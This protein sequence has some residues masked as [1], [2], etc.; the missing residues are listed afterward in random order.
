MNR[1]VNIERRK[2]FS[3]FEGFQ[4]K[5]VFFR[6]NQII[7]N[8]TCEKGAE[9]DQNCFF[10]RVML[11]YLLLLTGFHKLLWTQSKKNVSASDQKRLG[12]FCSCPSLL[13]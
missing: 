4:T 1:N 5:L 7:K 9:R 6:K 12:C 3:F 2:R 8:Q 11:V 13:F 10:W